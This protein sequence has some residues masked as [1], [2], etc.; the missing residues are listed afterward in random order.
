VDDDPEI[1]QYFEDIARSFGITC[2]IAGGGDEALRI[3]EENG[4]YDI[5]FID[6]KMPGMNGLE[7]S[8]QIKEKN[9]ERSVVTMISAAE[10]SSIESEAKKAG[11]DQFLPKPL[12]PSAIADLINECIGVYNPEEQRK[13]GERRLDNFKGCRLL[14]VEDV[15]INQEIVLALLEPTELLIDCAGNGAEALRIFQDE[16]EK[17][18]MIFMDVQMPEM[19]GYEATVRIRGMDI[20]RAKSIPIVAM[21]ANV[22]KEDVERALA[23]GMNDHLGKPLNFEE[24]LAKL[25]KY[26]PEKAQDKA[27]GEPSAPVSE[28]SGGQTQAVPL[29]G[30]KDID[31]QHKQLFRLLS[32]LSAA[33]MRG[34]GP[35]FL[36]DSL[37]FFVS[38]A[39]KH[40]EEEEAL[41]LACQYPGYEEHKELHRELH[42]T[43]AEL[44]AGYKRS[45]SA[46]ELFEKLNSAVARSLVEH[47]KNEDAKIAAFIG[48]RSKDAR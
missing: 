2:D 30:N 48:E 16:P 8:R 43:L 20:P 37:D 32:S 23:A 15:E 17:Y 45:G 27:E 9:K 39:S 19:D 35:A 44:I 22:F 12:F 14:L 4:A 28:S 13:K 26:L 47:I 25:R 3:I 1:R 34:Q 21:T 11:V 6:W 46:S 10:W 5:Y 31:S 33:C 38:Y 29:T 42:E 40:I 18:D 41:Q 24:V 36:D 7:L